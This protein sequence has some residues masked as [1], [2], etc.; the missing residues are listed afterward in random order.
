MIGQVRCGTPDCILI[1]HAS[2]R[3]CQYHYNVIYNT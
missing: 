1:I 3:P 2:T